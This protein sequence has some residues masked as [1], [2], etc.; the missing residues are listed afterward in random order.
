MLVKS[1]RILSA[2]LTLALVLSI[3][4]AFTITASA[5]SH[6]WNSNTPPTGFVNGDAIIVESGASGT[7]EIDPAVSELTLDGDSGTTTTDAKIN[8]TNT[9]NVTLTNRNLTLTAPD[10]QAAITYGGGGTLTLNLDNVTLNGGSN[11]SGSGGNG[12]DASTATGTVI[13]NATNDVNINGG[14][15]TN[16]GNY[17]IITAAG[18]EICGGVTA[19]GGTGDGDGV[20]ICSDAKTLTVNSGASLAVKGRYGIR[21]HQDG[22]INLGGTLTAIATGKTALLKDKVVFTDPAAMLTVQDATSDANSTFNISMSGDAT[23]LEFYKTGNVTLNSQTQA[24]STINAGTI[25]LGPPNAVVWD[26]DDN[27]VAASDGV[28]I[29]LGG[30]HSSKTTV[31]VVPGAAGT[32]TIPGGRDEITVQGWQSGEPTE[33]ADGRIV[34]EARASELLLT[35]TDLDITSDGY[36]ALDSGRGIDLDCTNVTLTGSYGVEQTGD[37]TIRLKGS[38]T[39]IGTVG[40]A[41]KGGKVVFTDAGTELTVRDAN[42]D[43]N[44]EIAISLDSNAGTLGTDYAFE[45][46]GGVTLDDPKNATIATSSSSIGTVSLTKLY[47]LTVENGTDNTNSSPYAEGETISITAQSTPAGQVFD[48]WTSDNGGTFASTTSRTTNFTMPDGNVTVTA[49]YRSSGGSS[50]GGGSTASDSLISPKTAA[51]VRDSDGGHGD[52]DVTLTANGNTLN[53]LTLGGKN[54]VRG[55]DYTVSGGTITLK[56][57]FLDTLAAGTY[58]VVFDMNRGA[59]PALTLIVSERTPEPDTQWVNPFIDVFESDWFYDHVRFVHQ[60]GL[61]YGTSANTFSPQMPM[62]R[63]MVATVLGRLAGIDVAEYSG[64]SFD[65]VDEDMYYAPYIKW[66]AE[67]GVVKGVGENNYAPEANISRQDLA[68]I[69][70]RYAVAMELLMMQT[71]RNAVFTD[72]DEIA[73]YAVEAVAAMVRARVI[74]GKSDGSFDPTADATR[75][76]VA[77]MLH[78]FCEAAVPEPDYTLPT[79]SKA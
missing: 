64:G 1:N 22:T 45:A 42:S 69:L 4:P 23:G 31:I 38:L 77:A 36:S 8:I 47:T 32:L 71:L 33:V 13:I 2:F 7:L 51:P 60:R 18:L 25:F 58:M 15:A 75:A 26:G 3:T 78:R 37:S 57:A 11:A 5:Q 61:F 72:S 73:D 55:T 10:G 67:F 29:D 14:D 79:D 49:T 68:V 27:G 12:I 70:Y 54:L 59:D 50:S 43:A 62:T 21:S 35:L 39:A 63:G 16:G 44:S 65:D 76:E 9:G 6:D 34:V 28:T 52:L 74:Y 41:I 53:N 56:S 17:G 40:T 48:G 46:S 24:T 20:Y 66:A 30:T 19:I